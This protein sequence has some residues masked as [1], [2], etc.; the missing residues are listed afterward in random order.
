MLD[1]HDGCGGTPFN[2]NPRNR[3]NQSLIPDLTTRQL[4]CVRAVS[5]RVHVASKALVLSAN[6][7]RRKLRFSKQRSRWTR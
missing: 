7:G 1:L 4:W 5:E 2:A 6:Y 3:R